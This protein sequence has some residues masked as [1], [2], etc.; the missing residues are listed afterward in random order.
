MANDDD[1]DDDDD[2]AVAAEHCR[3][4]GRVQVRGE[5]TETAVPTGGPALW[6]RLTD[7]RQSESRC[8]ISHRELDDVQSETAV[9]I[10]PISC[11]V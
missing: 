7:R 5:G 8:A 4:G 10:T 1:D 6:R 11:C 3:D 9:S 2:D